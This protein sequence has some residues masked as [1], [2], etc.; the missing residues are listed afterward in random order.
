VL[1]EQGGA[2]ATVGELP[3]AQR[4]EPLGKAGEQLYASRF[5]GA[6]GYLVTYR[7]TDPLYVLDLANPVDPKVAGQLQVAGYSDYLFPLGETLLLGVGKDAVSDGSA[8]DDTRFA[9]YQGVKVSLIDVSDPAQPKETARQVIGKR[10]TSATV[11]SDHHGI[12]IQMVGGTA[13][14]GLPVSVHET[15]SPFATGKPNDFYQYT[16]TELQRFQVDLGAR[17]LTPLPALATNLPAGE[18]PIASDRALL[19]NDQVH[20][21]Q[22]GVWRSGQW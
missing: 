21:F 13:R 11:L 16:R 9:W 20:W 3:N 15:P 7:L 10:G 22:G 1:K 17:Q 19:W 6:R 14:I 4:P 8:G 12:A 2:L 18:R 5:I